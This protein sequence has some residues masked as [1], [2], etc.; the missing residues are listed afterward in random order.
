MKYESQKEFFFQNNFMKHLKYLQHTVNKANLLA[1]NIPSLSMIHNK[2]VYF[3][4]ILQV[5]EC[6]NK[7]SMQDQNYVL[8]YNKIK[9]VKINVLCRYHMINKN[10]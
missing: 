3:I 7:S 4:Y 8:S 1:E 6:G 9:K 5:L 2:L 10:T